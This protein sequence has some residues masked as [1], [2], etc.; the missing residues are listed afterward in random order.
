MRKTEFIL[1][2]HERL[3][4][5]P[6][7]ERGEQ[8]NFYVEIIEDRMEEGFSEEEAVA[9]VGPVEQIAET[10]LAEKRPEKKRRG[11]WPTFLLVLG[12]PVWGALLIAALAVVFALY[13]SLWAV[14]ICL[15][16]AFASFAGCGLG[17]VASGVYFACTGYPAA[18][19]A[20]VGAG[21]VCVGLAIFSFYGCKA[22]TKG[23]LRLTKKLPGALKKCFTKREEAKQV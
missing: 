11:F 6:K 3:S 12:A 2:L 8:L 20:V 4:S 17:G 19:I 14:V 16:A 22:V 7:K 1:A 9:A 18:G 23:V 15:W 13:V 10:I 5:L 21:F